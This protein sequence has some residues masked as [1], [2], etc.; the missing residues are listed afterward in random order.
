MGRRKGNRGW[1]GDE[2]DMTRGSAP[3]PEISDMDKARAAGIRLDRLA[4]REVYRPM[5]EHEA[6][7]ALILDRNRARAAGLKVYIRREN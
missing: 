4:A 1:I 6:E 5:T 7:L 3:A 2:P